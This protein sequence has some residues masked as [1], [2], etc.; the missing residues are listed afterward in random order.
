MTQTIELDYPGS[1]TWHCVY[2]GRGPLLQI[3]ASIPI[4]REGLNAFL[5]SVCVAPKA[6][7]LTT[8]LITDQS[9]VGMYCYP[10]LGM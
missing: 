1:V 2:L 5:H 3:A 8:A 6:L 10:N 4:I 7:D 9:V